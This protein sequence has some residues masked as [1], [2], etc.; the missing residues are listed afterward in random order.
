MIVYIY[1]I[2][3]C[4][5]LCTGLYAQDLQ[6]LQRSEIPWSNRDLSVPLLLHWESP[7]DTTVFITAKSDSYDQRTAVYRDKVA[8]AAGVPTVTRHYLPAVDARNARIHINWTDSSGLIGHD[9]ASSTHSRQQLGVFIVNSDETIARDIVHAEATKIKVESSDTKIIDIST[10]DLP[11]VW[12][13]LPDWGVVVLTPSAM[14]SLA[15]AQRDAL[16]R[17]HRVT[18]GLLVSTPSL[19]REWA[20]WGQDIAA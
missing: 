9:Y 15:P 10:N 1:R 13:A 14:K 11:H 12:H 2:I 16:V 18:D 5:S 8:L 17:W 3:V 20:D 6:L 19:A 7:I 4:V